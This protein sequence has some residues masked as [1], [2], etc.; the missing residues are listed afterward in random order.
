MSFS[1][2]INLVAVLLLAVTAAAKAGAPLV[3]DDAEVIDAKSC[4]FEAW[5]TSGNSDRSYSAVPACNFFR[6]T[7]LSLGF[8][9]INPA[10]AQSTG[11]YVLQVKSQFA[12]RESVWAVGAVAGVGRR[13]G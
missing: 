2:R 3:T 8:S 12:K 10:E 7:E 6:N 5:V 11:Q 4:Q 13:S 9:G 1:L